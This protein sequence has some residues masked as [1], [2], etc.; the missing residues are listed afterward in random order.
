MNTVVRPMRVI[1]AL[2][3]GLMT[4]MASLLVAVPKVQAAPYCG[5]TWGSLPKVGGLTMSSAH[6][7]NVRA[8]RHDCFD[9]LVI[10]LDGAVKGYDVRYVPMVY[11]DG[12]GKAVPVAGAADIQIV[13]R[14]PAYDRYGRPTYRPASRTQL[15][16]V[17]GF[18]TLRQVAWAGS[19]EGQTT[20]AL[21]V[22]ARLPMRVFRL[23]GP[24]TGSRLVIDVAH[25]W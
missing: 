19:F 12:S 20:L 9:R 18:S 15:V 14:A 8:G 2:L 4:V 10:D 13:V 11:A 1:L 3:V 25:R 16:N 6:L 5:I 21:G 17:A 7:T 23:A 22:R 24:G